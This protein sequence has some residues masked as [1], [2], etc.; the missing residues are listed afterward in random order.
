VVLSPPVFLS[1]DEAMQVVR[2]EL[3]KQ[4]SRRSNV[5]GWHDAR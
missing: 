3:A 1:E 4:K 5:E 2:E